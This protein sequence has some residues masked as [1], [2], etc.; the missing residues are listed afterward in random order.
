VSFI[1]FRNVCF[2][3]PED[4][5]EH[6]VLR[7]I[8]LSISKGQFLSIIGANSSGKSTLGRLMNA[9]YIPV[10]GNVFVEGMNTSDLDMV[11]TIRKTIGMIFQ[12][13]D[14]QIVATTVEEEVA[15]GPEN[16]CLPSQEIRK[17]VDEAMELT[18]LC[19]YAQTP[20]HLLSGGQKQLLAIASV[21]SMKPSCIVFDEA[22]SLL[23]PKSRK[24]VI[25]K[26]I[27]LNQQGITIVL[28]T[29]RM[30]EVLLSDRVVVLFEGKIAKDLKPKELF[31]MDEKELQTLKLYPPEIIKIISRLRAEGCNVPFD[32]SNTN[33]LVKYLCP[34]K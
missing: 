22:T 24:M 1:D 17:R 18:G 4:S 7:G 12:N 21:L 8:D 6:L 20:P 10:S 26:V 14:N 9:L 28:I 34:S 19:S 29:H 32:V 27:E 30:E 2:R 31:A 25:Q 5:E 11:L 13:P 16:L 33:D 15:F 23:D 3:Y